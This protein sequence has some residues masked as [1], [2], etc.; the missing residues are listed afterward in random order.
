M[1]TFYIFPS[2]LVG[3]SLPECQE[4]PTDWYT[5]HRYRWGV[6]EGVIDLPP[7]EALPLESNLAFMNGGKAKTGV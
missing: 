6:P 3:E 5:V 4:C 2:S 1:S 7:T